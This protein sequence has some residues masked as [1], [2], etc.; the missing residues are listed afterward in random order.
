MARVLAQLLL[1]AVRTDTAGTLVKG[2]WITRCLHC[3]SKL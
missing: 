1:L 2:T 3:R